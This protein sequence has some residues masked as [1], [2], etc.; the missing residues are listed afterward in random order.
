MSADLPPPDDLEEQ[1]ARRP[2]PEPS[3]DFRARVLRGLADAH[4]PPTG[5]WSLVEVAVALLLALNL[6]MTVANMTR[7]Q[8]LAPPARAAEEAPDL[9]QTDT[10]TQ[11][12][13]VP[14]APDAGPLARLLFDYEEGH[15]WG[16]P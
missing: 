7:F 3:A 14:R 13:N 15:E 9:F 10:E 1:L 12:A 11:L 16:T 8:G 4:G 5:R 2:V 6:W